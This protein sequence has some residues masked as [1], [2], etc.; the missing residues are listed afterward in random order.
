[1]VVRCQEKGYQ[2]SFSQKK[3]FWQLIQIFCRYLILPQLRAMGNCF[4]EP[5][6]VVITEAMA[7]KY[8]GK[9]NAI[10]KTLLM[11]RTKKPFAVT[12]GYKKYP[13]QSSLQ[14]DFLTPVA[15]FPVVRRFSWSWVWQQMVCYVKLKKNVHIDKKAFMQIEAKFPAMVR[16]QAAQVSN[17]LGNHLMSF[18][19]TEANGIFI[20]CRSPTF[21]CVREL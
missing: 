16:V 1:M 19:K 20:Y 4:D 5:G 2:I 17:E 7:K 14:F 6:S 12:S 8:F 9:E 11:N 15:D 10:G 21:T 18:L 13:S 3:M